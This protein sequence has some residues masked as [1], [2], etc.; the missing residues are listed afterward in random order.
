MC[1][2]R[3]Y[4][5]YKPVAFL[6]LQ[7]KHQYTVAGLAQ[8]AFRNP[9]VSESHMVLFVMLVEDERTERVSDNRRT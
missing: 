1:Q 9:W 6:C 3:S 7:S 2:L 8:G 4:V 5:L